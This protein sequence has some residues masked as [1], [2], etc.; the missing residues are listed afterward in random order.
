MISII[1]PTRNEERD[2]FNT[3]ISLQDLRNQ[4]LCE[5]ILVD[6]MSVDKTVNIATQYVDKIITT[7][8][9]RGRQMNKGAEKAIGETLVFLHADTEITKDN[10]IRDIRNFHEWG[11]FKLSFD[12][13][14]LKYTILSFL[15][16]LRSILFN[17]ATGD[18]VIF[19][20][21]E[22]F[23]KIG[24][25]PDFE[26]MEDVYICS[27]LKKFLKPII[28]KSYVETSARRWEINGFLR[29]IFKMRMLRLLYYM[30]IK[31]SKLKSYYK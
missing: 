1:I 3:V 30:K 11:F 20:K 10:C 5:I 18:Q 17:Y 21:K 28:L 22:L 15:I 8:P 24:G 19:I 13:K 12:K 6:G 14:D 16:N 4:K 31:P 27:K 25:F 23:K 2:I 9:N 29:T 7:A 26:I